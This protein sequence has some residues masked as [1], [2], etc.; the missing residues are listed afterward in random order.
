M[1]DTDRDTPRP[2][3]VDAGSDATTPPPAGP[4]ASPGEMLREAREARGRSTQDLAESAKLSQATIVALEADDFELL[5]GQAGL[6]GAPYFAS[7]GM[8]WVQHYAE[9]GLSDEQLEEVLRQSHQIVGSGLSKKKQRELGL[10]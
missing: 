7:R 1:N 5:C 10:L 3:A 4:V 9:P 8:K 2:N 6:R